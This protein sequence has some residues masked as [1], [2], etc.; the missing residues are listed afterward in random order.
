MRSLAACDGAIL[1]VDATR[2]VQAQTLANLRL[3]RRQGLAVLPVINKV[4]SPLAEVDRVLAQLAE[5]DGVDIG[6]A[7]LVS[8][9]T[10]QGI[11]ELLQAII[12]ALPAP[13]GDPHGPVRA[14]VFDS[15]YDPYR[16]AVLHVRVVDGELR[17]GVQQLHFLSNGVTLDPAEV[18]VFTLRP[19][20][21]AAL[22][23]GQVGYLQAGVKDAGRV[24]ILQPT[25]YFNV[26]ATTS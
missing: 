9:K 16:G 23:T 19:R 14:L 15:H 2:G 3:A 4:D 7:V 26:Y 18:G 24:R 11:P 25:C 13:R 8:A 21:V 12:I 5:L 6:R 17:A 10:G 1:L 20:P 22:G